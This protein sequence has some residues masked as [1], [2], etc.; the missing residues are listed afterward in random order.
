MSS[1]SQALPGGTL[2][3]ATGYQTAGLVVKKQW[4]QPA[5][6]PCGTPAQNSL[7]K[8]PSCGGS[9]RASACSSHLGPVI[10]EASPPPS[11]TFARDAST[12]FH[13]KQEAAILVR[14]LGNER[15]QA[16]LARK[17]SRYG[18]SE[19]ETNSVHHGKATTPPG[20]LGKQFKMYQRTLGCSR[21]LCARGKP[22][23]T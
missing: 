11:D 20:F 22:E 23:T 18:V 2:L 7:E 6:Q 4:T 3:P 10:A 13:T 19:I 1:D 17:L 9:P 21:G 14:V 5:P 12:L 8:T 15:L 16:Q